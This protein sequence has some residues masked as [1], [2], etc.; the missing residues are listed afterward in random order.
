VVEPPPEPDPAALDSA[1]AD[2]LGAGAVQD[3]LGGLP[4]VPEDTLPPP[5][6]LGVRASGSRDR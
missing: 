6:T 2:T 4:A 3:T 1:A 5:D